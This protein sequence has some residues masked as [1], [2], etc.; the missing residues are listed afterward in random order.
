MGQALRNQYEP[1]T[2]LGM[3]NKPLEISGKRYEA[4]ELSETD[5]F[6]KFILKRIFYSTLQD[7]KMSTSIKFQMKT[8]KLMTCL[9]T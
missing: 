7:M 5:L 1:L 8:L 2:E 9:E 6:K 3:I 4:G